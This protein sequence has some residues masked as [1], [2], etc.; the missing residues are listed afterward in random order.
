MPV[1]GYDT[2]CVEKLWTGTMTRSARETHEQHG[3]HVRGRSGLNRSLLAVAPAEQ[4]AIL[5]RGRVAFADH[6]APNAGVLALV[7]EHPAQHGPAAVVYGFGEPGLA[8]T[9]RLDVAEHDLAVSV[10]EV[11]GP[12]VQRVPPLMLHLRVQV[13]HAPFLA[14]A[15]DAAYRVLCLSVPAAVLEPAPA[16][17]TAMSFRPRATPT[18]S[19]GCAACSS[20]AT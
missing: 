18:A 12:L 14:C 16:D 11:A 2:V 13:P 7:L 10:N 17:V 1:V 9:R 8:D 3:R 4:T 20:T 15:G 5:Q 19:P 6:L